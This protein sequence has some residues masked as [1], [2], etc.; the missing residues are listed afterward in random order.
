VF[1]FKMKVHLVFMNL[2]MHK[3]MFLLGNLLV[4]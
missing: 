2:H 4:F 3:T 1:H